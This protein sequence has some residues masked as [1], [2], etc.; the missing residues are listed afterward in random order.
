VASCAVVVVDAGLSVESGDSPEP[1]S[2]G[3]LVES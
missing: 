3:W 2:D 1:L